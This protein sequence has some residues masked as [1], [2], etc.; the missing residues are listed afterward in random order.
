MARTSAQINSLAPNSCHRCLASMSATQRINHTLDQPISAMRHPVIVPSQSEVEIPFRKLVEE[1]DDIFTI[2]ELDGTLHY[3]SPAFQSVIGHNPTA[4][5]GQ[6]LGSLIHPDDVGSYWMA[7]QQVIQTGE[8]RIGTVCR[9]QHQNG[10]WK[11]VIINIA[12]LKDPKGQVIQLQGMIRDISDR[13]HIETELQQSRQILQQILDTL[14]VCIFWKD[15]NSVYLGINQ[16]SIGA[17]GQSSVADVVGR[18]DYDMPW[19]KEEADWYRFCDQRVMNSGQAELNIIETQRRADGTEVFLNTN[20]VPL[21]DIDGNIIGILGTIEDISDRQAVET[22]LQKYADQQKILNQTLEATL[23]ELKRTQT[24]MLQS[25]KMSSLGQLVAG[26]AHEIN[27]PVNFIHGNLLPAHN[28]TKQLLYLISLY[29]AAYPEPLSAIVDK[30]DAIDLDFVSEDLPKLLTSMEIGTARIRDIVLSLR[31]FAR[32]DEAQFKWVDIH[33]GLES[34][35]ML[36]QNRLRATAQRPEIKVTR[37]YAK[38][39][40][41]E[42]FAGQIN[43]V[44]MNILINAIDAIDVQY[45]SGL[46]DSQLTHPEQLPSIWIVTELLSNEEIAIHLGNNGCD[47]PEE[48]HQK[49]FDPFF[50][51]KPIGAATGMGLSISYQIVTEEHNGQLLCHSQPSEGTT[52]SIH[53]PIQQPTKL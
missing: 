52:F 17:F 49:I 32:L 1:A 42:C 8:R 38:L 22:S 14:P 25:E 30:T 18:T 40:D 41:I 34:A 26:I 47:I 33:E 15:R 10:D 9:L 29:Q 35:I 13:Q 44:F 37:Q 45:Q 31:N 6:S 46:E 12:P 21:Q 16:A 27:N 43:Q 53:I 3:L 7:H 48:I 39:P 19:T 28:Y 50:T 11:W 5:V 24:H 23:Q 2:W 20:K 51:T 4:W 36:L